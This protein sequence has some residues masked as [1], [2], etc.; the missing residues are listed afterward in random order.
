MMEGM[1]ITESPAESPLRS[2]T[3]L[4]CI[5]ELPSALI[6]TIMMKLDVISLCSIASTCR[7][8]HGCAFHTLSFVPAFHLLDIA[9]TLD[10]LCPLL[11]RN[12][13]LESLKLDCDRLDDSS[14]K[15]LL[16]PSLSDLCLLNCKRFSGALLYTIGGT[17]SQL[18]YGK[19]WFI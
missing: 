2:S 14:F 4:M 16:R 13:Y 8:F 18:R 9:P 11:P 15:I 19:N 1:E 12:P 6:S 7:F 5:T 10:L 3:T 17:C